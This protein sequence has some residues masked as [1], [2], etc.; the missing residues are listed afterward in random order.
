M[1]TRMR[2]LNEPASWR[3][4]DDILE[5]VADAKTDFWRTTHYGF[6]R[7]NGHCFA[8]EW[9]G[10]FTARVTVR[11]AYRDQYDQAGLMVWLDETTWLKT[12][13][14]LVDGRPMASVVV[15]RQFSDWLVM[16]LPLGTTD[17]HLRLIRRGAA[18]EVRCAADDD[19]ETMLRLAYLTEELT[20][21]VGPMCSAPDGKGF[22]ATFRGFAVEVG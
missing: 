13:V 14:E 11:G 19:E 15:T 8:L 20:T 9:T 1:D 2:W 6:V 16:P 5:M 22:S 12:G 10:D 7:D 18:I 21:R 4:D 17:L 3:I